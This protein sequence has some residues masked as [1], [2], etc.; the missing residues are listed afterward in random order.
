MEEMFRIIVDRASTSIMKLNTNLVIDYVNKASFELLVKHQQEIRNVYPEF[1]QET[2]VGTSLNS[3]KIIPHK[4]LN[5]LR[6][7]KKFTNC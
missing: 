3:I 6:D 7:P 1:D 2:L 5:K 4:I